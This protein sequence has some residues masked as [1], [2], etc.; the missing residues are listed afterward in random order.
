MRPKWCSG[1]QLEF[2]PVSRTLLR[3]TVR[4][5]GDDGN[6]ISL[7]ILQEVADADGWW[8]S[9]GG[10]KDGVILKHLI[11]IAQPPTWH[12]GHHPRAWRS[13]SYFGVSQSDSQ[14][15]L[16]RWQ[17]CEIGTVDASGLPHYELWDS[18]KSFT[19]SN[20][21]NN[22]RRAE[23]LSADASLCEVSGINLNLTPE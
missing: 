17:K 11:S 3:Y 8:P 4:G 14:T 9:G 18:T 6:P 19:S 10:K 21:Q 23:L 7:T 22:P 1:A 2:Y 20:G 16:I 5:E 12:A 15:P 13:D